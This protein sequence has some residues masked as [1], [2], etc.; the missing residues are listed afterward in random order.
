MRHAGVG[1]IIIQLFIANK[2][3]VIVIVRLKVFEIDLFEACCEQLI[4]ILNYAAYYVMNLPM[5][6]VECRMMTV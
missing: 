3:I 1:I 6:D 2:Y 5:D 4:L